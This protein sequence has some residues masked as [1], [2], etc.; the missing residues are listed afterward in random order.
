MDIYT[1]CDFIILAKQKEEEER[2]FVQYC[3]MLPTMNKYMPFNEFNDMMTGRNIDT[4][5][6]DDIEQEI[7]R[8]HGKKVV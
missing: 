1:L 8:L 6:V 2:N 7:N 4:R 5:S 3:A